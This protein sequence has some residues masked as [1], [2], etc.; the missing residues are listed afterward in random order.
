MEKLHRLSRVTAADETDSVKRAAKARGGGKALDVLMDAQRYWFAM[1]TFRRD[2]ERNKN[3]AKA[4]SG[5]TW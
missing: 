2:R 1:D 3:Y 4:T 5:A